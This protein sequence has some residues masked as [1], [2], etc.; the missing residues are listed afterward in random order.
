M[1]L[2]ISL[3]QSY[4]IIFLQIFSKK[5]LTLYNKC[6]IIKTVKE[7]Q[8]NERKVVDMSKETLSKI[9]RRA[10]EIKKQ[11]KR[12]VWSE[13]LKMA[14][15]DIRET[16]EKPPKLVGSEKQIAWAVDIRSKFIERAKM[17]V[18]NKITLRD[19]RHYLFKSGVAIDKSVNH[20]EWFV[21]KVLEKTSAKWFIDNRNHVDA[22]SSS[23]LALEEYF[24]LGVLN[25]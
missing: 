9:M 23:L 19:L 7:E 24:G 10:W 17:A 16:K 22:S 3:L 11:D 2:N 1:D 21:N 6:F 4:C 13:C 25:K 15:E 12:N 18:N 20:V 8:I 14:W 5:S